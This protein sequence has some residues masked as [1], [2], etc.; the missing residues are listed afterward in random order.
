M[1][2]IGIGAFNAVV[3]RRHNL[4]LCPCPE[5]PR[6]AAPRPRPGLERTFSGAKKIDHTGV[7]AM[8]KI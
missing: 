5:S 1:R 6:R 8:Y 2:L 4:L 3:I 7:L